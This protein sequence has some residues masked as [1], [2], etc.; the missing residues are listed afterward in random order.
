MS[1]VNPRA[2][3]KKAGKSSAQKVGRT[4]LAKLLAFD[5][6]LRVDNQQPVIIGVDEVG[7]GCLA[8]PVT[9]AAV[10]LPVVRTRTNLS[11][12]LSELNDSKQLNA[13][14]RER[15][16]LIIRE[17]AFWAIEEASVEEI[18]RLN[19]VRASLTAMQR[20]V[21]RLLASVT[22]SNVLVIVDGHLKIPDLGHPQIVVVKGDG[23]SASIAAAS[24]IA[25]VH[26]DG[27]M[28]SLADSLPAYGWQKNKGYGS[29]THRQAIVNHGL[30]SWH[31][32]A[33]IA[34]MMAEMN[35]LKIELS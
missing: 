30:T 24:V 1:L 27:F 21:H 6:R 20:A 17:H 23:L 33:F 25:K 11:R 8:G 16:S 9:A 14:Q 19:I 26:R 15:L 5:E 13:E 12:S 35:Q 29:K 32:K 3:A 34:R 18:D 2:K 22:T 31:R 10:C 28:S 7:R 4:T